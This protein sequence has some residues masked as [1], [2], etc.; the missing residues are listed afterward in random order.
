MLPRKFCVFLQYNRTTRLDGTSSFKCIIARTHVLANIKLPFHTHTSLSRTPTASVAPPSSA[1]HTASHI[2]R[3]PPPP[4]SRSS[5][6]RPSGPTAPPATTPRRPSPSRRWAS[7]QRRSVLIFFF[8][9]WE[10]MVT[11][12]G[13]FLLAHHF[14]A[15]RDANSCIWV[16]LHLF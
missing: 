11:Y 5:A 12:F 10:L 7:R 3:C 6:R 14:S 15:Y 2:T 13:I 9:C 16:T 4:T 8:L 1:H